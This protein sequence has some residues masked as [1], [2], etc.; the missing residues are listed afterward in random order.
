MITYLLSPTIF[1]RCPE[2]LSFPLCKTSSVE[3][4]HEDAILMGLSEIRWM[5]R[6]YGNR[7]IVPAL[8]LNVWTPIGL[9]GLTPNFQIEYST[10][11]NNTS[12][13][14]ASIYLIFDR[15]VQK[16]LHIR[17]GCVVTVGALNAERI[18]GGIVAMGSVRKPLTSCP[19]LA[20]G[21]AFPAFR[22]VIQLPSFLPS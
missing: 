14:Q 1:H 22:L 4:T 20:F 13:T 5:W 16:I 18:C 21:K 8:V 3:K 2:K 10:A 7:M 19:L 15:P 11:N 17:C 6:Q 9:I 12:W